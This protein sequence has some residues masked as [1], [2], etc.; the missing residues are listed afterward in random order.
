MEQE[1]SKKK[2]VKKARNAYL[3][4]VDVL[5]KIRDQNILTKDEQI[6]FVCNDKTIVRGINISK[7]YIDSFFKEY[8]YRSL[9]ELVNSILIPAVEN[10]DFKGE[11]LKLSDDRT[12]YGM[13]SIIYKKAV[14]KGVK[15]GI[16]NLTPAMV[17]KI[18][19]QE[20]RRIVKR[21]F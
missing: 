21:D 5:I 13:D 6:D 12:N 2:K 3:R 20:M 19:Y 8:D 1:K 17:S 16:L 4:R 11:I 15:K 14:E 18:I 10:Y 7:D 9:S